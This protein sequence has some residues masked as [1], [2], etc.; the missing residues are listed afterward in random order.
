MLGVSISSHLILEVFDVS[1]NGL[2]ECKSQIYQEIAVQFS[3]M[4]ALLNCEFFHSQFFYGML[5]VG[6][7]CFTQTAFLASPFTFNVASVPIVLLKEWH[8]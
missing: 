6:W 7:F 1:F 4:D 3:L 2:I 5:I 8:C